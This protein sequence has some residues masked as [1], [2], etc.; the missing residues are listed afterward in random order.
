MTTL[1]KLKLS[2]PKIG[3]AG[4]T[5]YLHK[6]KNMGHNE[7]SRKMVKY[8]DIIWFSNDR[9]KLEHAN[10]IWFEDRNG[11]IYYRK[12]SL[13]SIYQRLP[14]YFARIND[15]Y[16]VNLLQPYLEGRING[17][18]IVV[19]RK[20]LSITRTYKENFERCFDRLYD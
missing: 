9:S 17:S 3:I 5:D 14:Q 19:K 4:L 15:R 10:Y 18:N 16:I 12:E 11:N 2:T 6:I 7:I 13:S 20:K 8:E 1:Q